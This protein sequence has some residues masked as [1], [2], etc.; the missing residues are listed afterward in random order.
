MPHSWRKRTH[1][2]LHKVAGHLLRNHEAYAGVAK[3][4]HKYWTSSNQSMAPAGVG[5]TN[6][7][8]ASII[9]RRKK[10]RGY[11]KKRTFAQKV[12][13]ANQ[14]FASEKTV[15]LLRNW[16]S[17]AAAAVQNVKAFSL[18]GNGAG[19]ADLQ[20]IFQAYDGFL[21]RD[22]RV[23]V[24]SAH[25]DYLCSNVGNTTMCLKVYAVVPKRDCPSTY[26]T[27][28]DAAWTT[29]L[30]NTVNMPSTVIGLDGMVVQPVPNQGRPGAT[31]FDCTEF[32]SM[33]TI[34][35]V[36]E[37]ILQPGQVASFNASQMRKG[38]ID[39]GQFI[40]GVGATPTV[41]AIKGWTLSHIF[42]H[43]GIGTTGAVTNMATFYPSSSL[44]VIANKTYK[45]TVTEQRNS[46][47]QLVAGTL[48]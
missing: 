23:N 19:D 1:D 17:A 37:Y 18:Y 26:A 12:L 4:L 32:C 33:F 27:S 46:S 31:P 22:F 11:R 36:T 2:G 7:Y 41:C 48:L 25:V 13:R 29:S 10:N 3:G 21:S 14:F 24:K 20:E 47:E 35:K 16:S 9:Y 43:H 30:N 42:V 5:V 34:Q 38:A 6:Q 8:D 40:V 44:G 15:S 45:F 39:T 28:V